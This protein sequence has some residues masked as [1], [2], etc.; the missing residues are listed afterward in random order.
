MELYH[1]A[2]EQDH[3]VAQ[4]V[5]GLMYKNGS[6][7]TMDLS[8]AMEWW[9]KAASGGHA[10]AQE[11]LDNSPALLKS[12]NSNTDRQVAATFLSSEGIEKGS[13]DKRKIYQKENEMPPAKKGRP[14]HAQPRHCMETVPIST[15]KSPLADRAKSNVAIGLPIQGRT[16]NGQASTSVEEK[17]RGGAVDMPAKHAVE[18]DCAICL[19]AAPSSSTLCLS[20]LRGLD[21]DIIPRESILKLGEEEMMVDNDGYFSD[22]EPVEDITDD[23]SISEVNPA[24][25]T[26]DVDEIDDDFSDL[27]PEKRPIEYDFLDIDDLPLEETISDDFGDLALTKQLIDDEEAALGNSDIDAIGINNAKNDGTH[28]DFYADNAGEADNANIEDPSEQPIT[29]DEQPANS[30]FMMNGSDV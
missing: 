28:D 21:L 9:S 12:H 16:R 10:G 8:K 3:T 1:K 5:L 29:S 6:G 22:T 11:L 4:Y 20:R 24:K 19:G 30:Y 2:A 27:A 23:R 14:K 15:E 17:D 26:I 7:T 25:D 13:P 18:I